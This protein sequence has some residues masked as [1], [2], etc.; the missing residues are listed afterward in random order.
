VDVPFYRTGELAME[1]LLELIEKSPAQPIVR[2]LPVHMI[3]RAST[4]I[5]IGSG[6]F[7]REITPDHESAR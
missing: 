4:S 3:Y 6:R 5:A 7:E 2:V 1:T